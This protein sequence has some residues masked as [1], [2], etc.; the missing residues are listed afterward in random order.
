M[1]VKNIRNNNGNAVKN[2][3]E[4]TEILT[5]RE[6]KFL[7][8]KYGVKFEEGICYTKSVFQ[9][10]NSTIVIIL[11]NGLLNC[12]QVILDDY[13]YNY[14]KT[15]STYRNIFLKENTKRI[16]QKIKRNEY[17]LMNLN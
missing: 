15:T 4:I 11:D 16:L 17:K 6:Y 9:S 5:E 10:Y 14:S 8:K 7:C 12:K 2:Q 13:Y 3:F 1:K